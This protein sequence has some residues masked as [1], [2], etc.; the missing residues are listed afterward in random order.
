MSA[1]SGSR[2]AMGSL[3]VSLENDTVTLTLK[4]ASTTPNA[5]LTHNFTSKGHNSQTLSR[6]TTVVLSLKISIL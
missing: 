2:E 1:L 6:K 4:G 3:N 5:K